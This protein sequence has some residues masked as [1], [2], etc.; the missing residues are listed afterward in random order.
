MPETIGDITC[1]TLDDVNVIHGHLCRYFAQHESDPIEPPG[2]RDRG[3]LQSAVGRQAAG[4][5]GKLFYPTALENA[6]SLMFGICQNHPFFNGNKRTALVCLVAHLHENRCALQDISHEELYD[7]V[8][9]LAN[10]SLASKLLQTD[11]REAARSA[12]RKRKIVEAATDRGRDMEIEMLIRVL[13]PYVRQ[14]DRQY[15]PMS[16]KELHRALKR[17]GFEFGAASG[18]QIELIRV[19]QVTEPRRWFRREK[20]IDQRAVIGKVPNSGDN[21]VVSVHEI[22]RIRQMARLTEEFGVDSKT[23]FQGLNPVD[24][25]IASHAAVLRMLR[26]YDQ[27]KGTTR[28]NGSEVM[29]R[30]GNG[31]SL[32][33]SR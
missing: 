21:R 32:G 29:V 11:G 20:T 10:H 33:K 16:V 2:L 13:R 25:L 3:L 1:L 7:I 4:A 12:A 30:V 26:D 17:L 5:Y 18:N 22:K 31:L 14:I 6:C 27:Q 28:S 8:V 15:Y 9:S 23:F 24:S 19:T